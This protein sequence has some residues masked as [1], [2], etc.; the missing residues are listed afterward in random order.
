MLEKIE[1]KHE[2]I[3]DVSGIENVVFKNDV[4]GDIDRIFKDADFPLAVGRT[5]SRKV[6]TQR[7]AGSQQQQHASSSNEHAGKA[8]DSGIR[9]ASVAEHG[10]NERRRRQR[11]ECWIEE[12]AGTDSVGDIGAGSDCR[13]QVRFECVRAC[14]CAC[15]YICMRAYVNLVILVLSV[16]ALSL[17]TFQGRAAHKLLFSIAKL[18]LENDCSH[19]Q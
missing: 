13:K 8:G 5:Y 2:K 19:E 6:F 1:K 18:N 4:F 15:V 12:A 10:G 7:R 9:S 3:T 14:I 17:D 11:R 16:S